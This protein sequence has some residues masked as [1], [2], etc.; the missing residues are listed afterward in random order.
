MITTEDILKWMDYNGLH[1]SDGVDSCSGYDE[2]AQRQA[3]EELVARLPTVYV[4]TRFRRTCSISP[5]QWEGYLSDGRGIYVRYRYGRGTVE[6]GKTIHDAVMGQLIFEWGDG[7]TM[8]GVCTDE[9]LREVTRGVLRFEGEA[10]SSWEFL[11][12]GFDG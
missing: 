8:N 5:S 7:S 9:E 4:V 1:I 6:I 2:D 10:A 12:D 3:A 11:L